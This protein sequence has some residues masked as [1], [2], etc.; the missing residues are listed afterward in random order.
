MFWAKYITEFQLGDL[1]LL[2][3]LLIKVRYCVKESM[4]GH[5]RPKT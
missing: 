3:N 4:K 2:A 1:D 5:L